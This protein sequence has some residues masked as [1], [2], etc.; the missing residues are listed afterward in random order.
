MF[1][2][3]RK[4]ICE[5]SF[6][7]AGDFYFNHYKQIM[8]VAAHTVVFGL[9]HLPVKPVIKLLGDEYAHKLVL[10]YRKYKDCSNKIT[11]NDKNPHIKY[12]ACS[13]KLVQ[14]LMDSTADEISD[15]V[16]GSIFFEKEKMMV[17]KKIG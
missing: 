12:A 14:Y 5:T 15:R 13:F 1:G 6:K 2:K 4:I 17:N 11:E 8:S 10:S 3:P 16:C 7:C 9:K